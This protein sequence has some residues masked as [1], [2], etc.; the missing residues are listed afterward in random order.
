MQCDRRVLLQEEVVNAKQLIFLRLLRASA[1]PP[2]LSWRCLLC[3][4]G[5]AISLNQ[6]PCHKGE[7]MHRQEEQFTLL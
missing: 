3:T 2:R 7:G 4:V 1:H 5:T 6:F